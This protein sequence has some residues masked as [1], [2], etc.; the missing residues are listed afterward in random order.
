MNTSRNFQ[1]PQNLPTMIRGHRVMTNHLLTVPGKATEVMRTFHDRWFTWP[2]R[3]W[4]KTWM[5]TPRIPDPHI[6]KMS[7]MLDGQCLVMHPETLK[8]VVE[9]EADFDD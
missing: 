5:Y 2:W 8:R 6:Y 3:P 7:D 4:V 1:N 9:I